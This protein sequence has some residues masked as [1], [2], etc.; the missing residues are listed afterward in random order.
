M[1]DTA[2]I[3]V[4]P[5]RKE[6]AETGARLLFMSGSDLLAYSF[7]RTPEA[8]IQLLR[9]LW[10]RKEHVFSYQWAYLAESDS[11]VLGIISAFTSKELR[12]ASARMPSTFARVLWP[13]DLARIVVHA[14]E[15][16]GLS[17]DVPEGDYYVGNLA[18]VP[19]A[20]SQG[21]GHLLLDFANDQARLRGC[22][23]CALDVIIENTRAI[24]LYTDCGYVVTDTNTSPRLAK[25]CGVSG[26]HRMVK[27]L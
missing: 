25:R 4:R 21:I 3:V 12:R 17:P 2:D 26:M 11:R 8:T 7:N 10:P 24:E 9:R 6:E 19:E 22:H 15:M 1:V 16:S 20:R 23:R 18:V 14:F 13:W 27:Q 5:A